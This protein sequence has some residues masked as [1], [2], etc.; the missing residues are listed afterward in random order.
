MIERAEV[1]AR[2]RIAV[3]L[4]VSDHAGWGRLSSILR[5]T[6]KIRIIGGTSRPV[7]AVRLARRFNPDIVFAPATSM[8]DTALLAQEL[9]EASPTSKLILMGNMQDHVALSA[10]VHLQPQLSIAAFL[11]WEDVTEDALVVAVEAVLRGLQVESASISAEPLG[12]FSGQARTARHPLHLTKAELE[13]LQG[14]MGDLKEKEIAALQHVSVRTIEDTVSR[15]KRK[16]G[17]NTV[18]GLAARA[19]PFIPSFC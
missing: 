17:V 16:F 7:E 14:L 15:L 12:H 11:G 3:L 18:A 9:G 1:Q 4:V 5:N 10:R 13:V 8:E 6:W 19:G 2:Q